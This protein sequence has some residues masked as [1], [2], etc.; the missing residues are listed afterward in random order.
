MNIIYD[1]VLCTSSNHGLHLCHVSQKYIKRF[2]SYEAYTILMLLKG[3]NSVKIVRGV[4]FLVLCILSNNGLNMYQ[5]WHTYIEWFQSYEA[6]RISTVI[7]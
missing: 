3:Q 1:G 6:E 5:V 2:Q 4:I 7:I